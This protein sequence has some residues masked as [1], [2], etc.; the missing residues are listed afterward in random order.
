MLIYNNWS[1]LKKVAFAGCGYFEER[2][3]V[4]QKMEF[5]DDLRIVLCGNNG[6][7]R[8]PCTVDNC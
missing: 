2:C 1:L 6:I 3:L 4:W 5:V 7:S 8:I